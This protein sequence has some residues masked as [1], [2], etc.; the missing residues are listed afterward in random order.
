M[1]F[2]SSSSL[3][4]KLLYSVFW[5]RRVVVPHGPFLEAPVLQNC[6]GSVTAVRELQ[7]AHAQ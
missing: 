2:T 3:F 1:T 7:S 5:L 6:E 4:L